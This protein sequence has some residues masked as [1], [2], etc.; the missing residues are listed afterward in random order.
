MKS[1]YVRKST[2]NDLATFGRIDTTCETVY[3]FVEDIIRGDGH[4]QFIFQRPADIF[5]LTVME[6]VAELVF[7]DGYQI[8]DTG[9]YTIR[10]ERIGKIEYKDGWGGVEF[11]VTMKGGTE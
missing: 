1:K 6:P 7:K 10:N 8:H 4:Y 11:W 5:G 3:E 2:S 9:F